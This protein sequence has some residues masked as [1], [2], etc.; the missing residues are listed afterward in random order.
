MTDAC[1]R[2]ILLALCQ[3]GDFRSIYAATYAV[4]NGEP[5]QVDYG[6]I[7]DDFP[8]AK[9]DRATIRERY[10]EL[11]RERSF[12]ESEITAKLEW[13]SW[14]DHHI[15]DENAELVRQWEEIGAEKDALA[16]E[17]ERLRAEI[18]GLKGERKDCR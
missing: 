2:R 10:E 5:V 9:Q 16:R 15:G 8:L 11:K 17:N 14:M 4:A 6:F 12:T 13:L 3:G 7:V 18:A 1:A